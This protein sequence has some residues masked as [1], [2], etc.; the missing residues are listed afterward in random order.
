[1]VLLQPDPFLSELTSLYEKNL[2]SGSVWVTM[3]RSCLKTKNKRE[4]MEKEG[5]KIEYKC[6][7]RATDGK[8]IISTLIAAKDQLKFQASY[9]T[10][11][12]AHMDALK[13]RE[14]K[15]R[16]KATEP[17]KKPDAPKK[18]VPVK[19]PGSTKV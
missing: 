7:V 6:L 5:Q 17:A 8:K 2:E 12:R 4:Q 1:M 3:K 19:K 16:K 9:A 18:R 10:V 11:L 13:K 14:R 15:D